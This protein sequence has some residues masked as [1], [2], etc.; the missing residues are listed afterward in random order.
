[1]KNKLSIIVVAVFII[2]FV[3]CSKNS[4]S[5]VATPDNNPNITINGSSP[6]DLNGVSK[7]YYTSS[8]NNDTILLVNSNTS[9]TTFLNN[10]SNI[11]SIP[12]SV[13]FLVLEISSNNTISQSTYT[14]GNNKASVAATFQVNANRYS[15]VGVFP[16]TVTVE[17]LNTSFISGTYTTQVANLTNTTDFTYPTFSGKFKAYFK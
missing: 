4:P 17:T 7:A 9:D 13:S 1:M 16:C 14:S 3:A 15:S 11:S 12:S 6:T 10:L 2:G 5:S 8:L